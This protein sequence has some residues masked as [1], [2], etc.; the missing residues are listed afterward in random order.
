MGRICVFTD[1][2]KRIRGPFSAALY[3]QFS[4][5]PVDSYEQGSPRLAHLQWPSLDWRS[6]CCCCLTVTLCWTGLLNSVQQLRYKQTGHT[7]YISQLESRLGH[8]KPRLGPRTRPRT[9]VYVFK[10]A[11]FAA[12]VG[13]VL[14]V[15]WGYIGDAQA[16][17]HAQV[18]LL[19]KVT[20]SLCSNN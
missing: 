18:C 17:K 12:Q 19:I 5:S 2:S 11:F 6:G 13:S 9:E 10:L 20:S 7:G 4:N 14:H 3:S 8:P 1:I 15:T 16:Y